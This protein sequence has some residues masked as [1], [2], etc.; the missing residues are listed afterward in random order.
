M[1][2]FPE[3]GESGRYKFL[4]FLFGAYVYVV[5]VVGRAGG[6]EF[7]GGGQ[8]VVV[9]VAE[10]EG[11]GELGELYGCCAAVTMRESVSRAV[12]IGIAGNGE[13]EFTA[14]DS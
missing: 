4:D 9:Y 5:E 1:V 8:I 6:E 12:S 2:Y 3:L 14:P 10:G 11:G 13:F 7:R